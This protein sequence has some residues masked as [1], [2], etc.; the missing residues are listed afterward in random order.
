MSSIGIWHRCV[1]CLPATIVGQS[2]FV[3]TAPADHSSYVTA[4]L[5]QWMKL[6]GLFMRLCIE[7]LPQVLTSDLSRNVKRNISYMFIPLFRNI[8]AKNG[9][10]VPDIVALL[11][12]VRLSYIWWDVSRHWDMLTFEN[13][14]SEIWMV[15]IYNWGGYWKIAVLSRRTGKITVSWSCSLKGM[16]NYE[17]NQSAKELVLLSMAVSG[18]IETRKYALVYNTDVT[19]A[20]HII[21]KTPW[22]VQWYCSTAN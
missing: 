4:S 6:I 11:A 10:G 7:I 9:A 2:G 15:I 20:V 22:I 18:C 16:N 5:L 13:Y 12:F 8:T 14:L 1:I 3:P 21:Q 17:G 19:G